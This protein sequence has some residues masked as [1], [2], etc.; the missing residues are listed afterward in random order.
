MPDPLAPAAGA[1]WFSLLGLPAHPLLDSESIRS[2]FHKSL[3]AHPDRQAELL[4]A[5]D[6]LLDPLRRMEHLL[7]RLPSGVESASE[8][9]AWPGGTL[10]WE[11][12]QTLAASRQLLQAGP[13]AQTRLQK[14]LQRQQLI[15]LQSQLQNHLGQVANLQSQIEESLSGW[16]ELPTPADRRSLLLSAL[17]PLRFLLRWKSQIE[18]MLFSIR[19]QTES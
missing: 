19:L 17:P 5:R 4:A 6:G 2:A 15:P 1:D 16:N 14:A 8:N 11:I 3:R 12:Q 13:A 10:G 9:C 7:D 18:E